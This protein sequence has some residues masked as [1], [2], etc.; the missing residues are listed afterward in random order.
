MADNPD[1]IT[2]I[3]AAKQAVLG[4]VALL[5]QEF[6]RAKSELKYD[7][8]RVT[9]VD[10]A[11]S[12]NIEREILAQFPGDEFFSEETTG[13]TVVGLKARFAWVIDPIDGTNNYTAGIAYC[14]ISLAL[15]ENGRPVYG[16]IYLSLIHI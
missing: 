13:S 9:A 11:I 15:L 8:T 16:V 12:A 2:R 1:F 4:Q 14:A 6:G 7:G 10:I 5:Q 3:A